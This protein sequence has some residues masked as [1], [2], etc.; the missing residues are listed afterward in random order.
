MRQ[1]SHATNPQ[2][3]QQRLAKVQEMRAIIRLDRRLFVAAIAASSAVGF[4]VVQR[5]KYLTVH[6]SARLSMALL[7]ASVSRGPFIWR[8]R[9]TRHSVHISKVKPD[10]K[11]DSDSHNFQ[12]IP[13][14]ETTPSG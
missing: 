14:I 4:R 8:R 7:F 1:G 10:I 5:R 6:S 11:P 12:Q 9:F 3:N 2:V 13:R